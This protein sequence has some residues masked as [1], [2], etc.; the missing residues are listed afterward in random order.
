MNNSYV[1]TLVHGTW[2][3]DAVWTRED[4][5]LCQSLRR[6]IGQ[7]VIFERFGWSGENSH[8]ARRTAGLE[9]RSLLVQLRAKYP[10]SWHYVIAH[11]HG[12]NLV[13]HALR[14][15]DAPVG[16]DGVACLGSPFLIGKARDLKAS[17]GLVKSAIRVAAFVLALGLFVG[18]FL[19]T[20][21]LTPLSPP[22]A[23]ALEALSVIVSVS[24]GVYMAVWLAPRTE[25]RL[26]NAATSKSDTLVRTRFPHVQGVPF[27]CVSFA[28]DEAGIFLRS[29]QRAAEV[30]FRLWSIILDVTLF[31]SKGIQY[32][33]YI[34]DI[35]GFPLSA[36]VNG[37]R[38]L[39][40]GALAIFAALLLLLLVPLAMVPKLVRG[41]GLGFGHETIVENLLVSSAVSVRPNTSAPPPL[42]T[43]YALVKAVGRVG[44]AQLLRRIVEGRL[45]HSLAYEDDIVLGDIAQWFESTS[46][47]GGRSQVVR[48]E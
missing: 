30:P 21:S 43:E 20:M 26:L 5:F 23:I 16:I 4:S 44:S 38:I 14:D 24:L 22:M 48:V 27:L 25:R 13:I 11:S 15:E 19:G 1:I 28:G 36:A 17:A 47:A 6:H 18:I 34:P 35:P 33:A 41:H 39:V 42:V 7:Q 10:S 12:G 8:M 45:L 37:G 29:I 31:V 3:R 46:T 9:L 32:T 2:A 40:V